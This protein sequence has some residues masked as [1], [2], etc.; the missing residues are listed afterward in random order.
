ML[1]TVN[2]LR[3]II[4]A[5]ISERVAKHRCLDFHRVEEAEELNLTT[6]TITC[7]KTGC[8]LTTRAE[9]YKYIAKLRTIWKKTHVRRRVPS[10]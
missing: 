10:L 4:S 9:S 7:V 1:R 3:M 8:C 6:D 2:V 5:L